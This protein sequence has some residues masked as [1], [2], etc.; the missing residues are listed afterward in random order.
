MG[1]KNLE[2]ATCQRKL[3]N[4]IIRHQNI[5]HMPL[6][7]TVKP[8]SIMKADITRRRRITLTRPGHTRFIAGIT[9]KK[10]QRRMPKSTAK[11]SGVRI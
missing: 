5:I 1:Q 10:R 2:Q 6:G 4:I 11:S 9:L 3:L 8:P 7:T